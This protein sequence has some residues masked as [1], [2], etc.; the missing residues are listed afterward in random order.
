M[1]QFDVFRNPNRKT[2]KIIPYLLDVQ[3]NLLDM[4]ATRVVVPLIVADKLKAA[5]R[6]KRTVPSS[7][8]TVSIVRIVNSAGLGGQC[9]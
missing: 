1:A 8:I 7:S 3:S 9:S 5:R 4:L 2:N 6:A